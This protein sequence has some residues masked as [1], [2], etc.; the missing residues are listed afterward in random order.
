MYCSPFE[1]LNSNRLSVEMGYYL[2]RLTSMYSSN[3][4]H[5]R[6][7]V[8]KVETGLQL[9]LVAVKVKVESGNLTPEAVKTRRVIDGYR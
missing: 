7:V 6:Y 3:T 9:R 5:I 8:Y 1:L 2:S 4:F